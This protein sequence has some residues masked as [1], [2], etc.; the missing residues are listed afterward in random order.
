MKVS[1]VAE[2]IGGVGS[3]KVLDPQKAVIYQ[4]PLLKKVEEHTKLQIS[5]CHIYTCF[6]SSMCTDH[7]CYGL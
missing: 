6:C 3:G 2:V 5:I 1:E 4:E 7:Y